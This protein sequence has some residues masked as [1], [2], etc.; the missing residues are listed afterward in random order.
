MN[1]VIGGKCEAEE[2]IPR[3]V[4]VC[5]CVHLPSDDTSTAALQENVN[6]EKANSI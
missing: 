6:T 4:C 3:S 1:V 2:T 5:V